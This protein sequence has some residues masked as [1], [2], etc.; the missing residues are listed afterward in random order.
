MGDK[1]A[2]ERHRKAVAEVPAEWDRKLAAMRNDP[3][4]GEKI[5]AIMDAWGRTKRRPKA[6]KTY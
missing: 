2:E 4:L 6:G 3:K 1:N 5:N